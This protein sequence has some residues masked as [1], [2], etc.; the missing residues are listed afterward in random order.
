MARRTF[1]WLYLFALRLHLLGASEEQGDCWSAIFSFGDSLADTGGHAAAFPFSIASEFPPYGMTYFH[2]PARRSSD[3]R[4]V[5]DFLTQG[6]NLPFLS[7]YLEGVLS[8]FQHG[9]NFAANG[10]IAI[11]DERYASTPFNLPVQVSQFKAFKKKV[12]EANQF[13]EL[14]GSSIDGT[15]V[16]RALFVV[17]IGGN[18]L[19]NRFVETTADGVLAF[20]PTLAESIRSTLL[21]LYA[22]GARRFLV[23]NIP[24]QGCCPFVLTYFRGGPEDYDEHGCL[25]PVNQIIS[26]YNSLLHGVVE[27]LRHQLAGSSFIYADNYQANLDIIR[28][29]ESHGITNTLQACCGTEGPYNYNLTLPCGRSKVVDGVERFYTLCTNPAEFVSWDGIH[30]TEA[31]YRI[32]GQAFL[33]GQYLEPALPLRACP[34]VTNRRSSSS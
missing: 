18:D 33:A 14:A 10:A 12:S 3:G 2:K 9:A 7:P 24:A 34:V 19:K 11:E 26:I 28:D 1:L 5:I 13:P 25:R 21:E 20:L 23:A 32:V 27:D 29:A 15:I 6:L 22:E 30:F 8:N 16:Q 31:F 17:S 4:L